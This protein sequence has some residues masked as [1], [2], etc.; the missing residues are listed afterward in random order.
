MVPDDATSPHAPDSDWV[1]AETAA[2]LLGVKRATLYA[3]VSRGQVASRRVGRGRES[4]YRR[5]DLD[6]LRTRGRGGAGAEQALRWGDPVLESSIT[7][8]TAQGPCYRGHPVLDLVRDGV[9]F[10]R[11]A[12]LLWT[13]SLPDASLRWSADGEPP[14][15]R[16]Y[17][18][19]LPADAP[20]YAVVSS[21][22]P[23]VA[24]HDPGR[25]DDSRGGTLDRARRLIRLI[26]ASLALPRSP[27]RAMQAWKAPTIAGVF[28][29]AWRA[30]AGSEELLDTALVV[31]AD[32]ELNAS[33]FA[34]R[35]VASTGADLYASLQ[36]GMAALSGPLHGAA[37]DRVE[38]LLAE[39]GSAARAERTIHERMRRG[40]RLP[41]FGHPFYPHGDPRAVPLLE[42]AWAWT[43]RTEAL[44]T[45]DRIVG[46]MELSGKPAPN[47]DVGLVGLRAALDLPIGSASS[48]FCVGR[49]AGWVAHALE[50]AD[51]GHLLRPRARYRA[52]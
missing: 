4:R 20:P 13:G 23:L 17:A 40:E 47:V 2:D 39:A 33:T 14:D 50:Q 19:L 6:A 43:P 30:P 52:P 9:C 24:A 42:G 38:A 18:D 34:T 27:A 46:A 51:S 32:H 15:F 7:E 37:T 45:L 5:A 16:R 28:A 36:A 22:V 8:M 29:R 31:L 48:L 10:E 49:C 25:F 44:A 12:E 1:D 35:V 21:V 26:A 3:Y 11:V 41:G